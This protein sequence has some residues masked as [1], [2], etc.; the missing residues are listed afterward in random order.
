MRHFAALISVAATATVLSGC[1]T[2][3]RGEQ[4]TMPEQG[5]APRVAESPGATS[6]TAAVSSS[7]A[8]AQST[9]RAHAQDALKRLEGFRTTGASLELETVPQTG[10]RA[11]ALR[12]NLQKIKMP[13]GFKIDL[14]AV[15]PDARHMG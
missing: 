9:G 10:P 12:A 5:A 6:S 2:T 4:G 14:Y 7:M 15:V 8:E 3:P 11:N 1:A 13:A